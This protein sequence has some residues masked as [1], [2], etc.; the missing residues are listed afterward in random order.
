MLMAGAVAAGD[1]LGGN[2]PPDAGRRMIRSK[3]PSISSIPEDDIRHRRRRRDDD[4]ASE[5][6][7]DD[8]MCG[9]LEEDE[10]AGL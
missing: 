5:D 1:G 6:F 4:V 10:D 3:K 7:C 8:A 9:D 2:V